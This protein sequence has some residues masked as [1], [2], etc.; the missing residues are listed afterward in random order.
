MTLF[1]ILYSILFSFIGIAYQEWQYWPALPG[2]RIGFLEFAGNRTGKFFCPHKL[3]KIFSNA[4]I[5][6]LAFAFIPLTFI[7]ACRDN[8]FSL[9]T[10]I[11][12]QHLNFLH[13]WV[14]RVMFVLSWVHTI[15]WSLELGVFYAPQPEKYITTWGKRYW[16]WGVGAMALL[17]FLYVHSFR[18]VQRV[19][20]YEFFR[21]SHELIAV[22]FLGACWGHWPDMKEWIIAGIAI[23]FFDRFVRYARMFAIHMNWTSGERGAFGFRA[24]E[25]SLERFHDQD[26]VDNLILRVK[27]SRVKYAAGQHFYLT[28]PS[29][30]P[31]ESHPFTPANAPN[32]SQPFEQ[33]YVIRVLKGQT[34]RLNKLCPEINT[35]VEI[36]VVVCG[37]YGTPVLDDSARNM[38]FVGGGTGVSFTIPLALEAIR[39][40]VVKKIG[41]AWIVR[42][43]ENIAWFDKELKEIISEAEKAGVQLWTKVFVTREGR[44]GSVTSSSGNSSD[45]LEKPKGKLEVSQ[46]E[47]V[48]G[49]IQTVRL[50][51]AHPDIASLV[52]DFKRDA[53]NGRIQVLGSGPPELGRDLRV[54]VA[55]VNSGEEVKKGDERGSVG[56]YWDS[57]EF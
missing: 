51:G 11:S 37:P 7:L 22:L 16:K 14:G 3:S 18:W 35:P 32:D 50:G 28:F 48:P 45:D 20:G 24:Y 10:G 30:S 27:G 31:F 54:A 34:T 57:R 52:V 1:V 2:R 6:C 15:L 4:C 9:V 26:G 23:V 44:E 41:F 55:G 8:I 21:K 36:P 49:G 13:K 46:L 39:R 29:L 43:S 40:G 19:L 12:H 25:G 53:V 33:L 38:L 5:G 47:K 56:L 42:R 17:T